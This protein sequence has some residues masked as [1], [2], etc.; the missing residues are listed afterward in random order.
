MALRLGGV[1]FEVGAT[2]TG[3][4]S[5]RHTPFGAHYLP[6]MSDQ[7]TVRLATVADAPTIARQR[8]EMF[9]DMGDLP[10]ELYAPLEN[11]ARADLAAWLAAGEYVGWVACRADRPGEIVAGAGIQLRGLLPRPDPGRRAL[12]RG[13]E[14]IVLNVFTDRA[15]RRRGVSRRLMECVIEWAR[16]HGVARLVLHASP[17]GRALYEQLG[18]VATNEMRYGGEL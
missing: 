13:Q 5:R 14:A 9:R 7:F 18:F 11:A 16:A 10:D 1:V 8:A 6:D 17:E 3:A 15:W 12:R 4:G 2:V